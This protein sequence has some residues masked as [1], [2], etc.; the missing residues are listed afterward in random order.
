M[1]TKATEKQMFFSD[2][3]DSGDTASRFERRKQEF[4]KTVTDAAVGDPFNLT[5]IGVAAAVNSKF[6]SVVKI[7][8]AGGD[9]SYVELPLTME[10]WKILKD[11]IDQVLTEALASIN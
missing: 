9:G 4:I 2:S 3:A 7:I 5:T 1:K 11:R 6:P 8:L 10:A